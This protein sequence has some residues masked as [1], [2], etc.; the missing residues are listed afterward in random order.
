MTPIDH[1]QTRRGILIAAAASLVCA[2]A[3]VQ[4]RSL[5]RVRGFRLRIRT[6]E[7]RIPKTQAE[8]YQRSFYNNLDADLSAG[9]AM[10]FGTVGG[11]RITRAEG[12]R[13]VA[14]AR[15]RGWLES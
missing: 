15:A 7:L 4:A 8:W 12:Y 14:Q 11:A 3:I 10:T 5:M 9:R 13:I 6:S 2:P 1:R